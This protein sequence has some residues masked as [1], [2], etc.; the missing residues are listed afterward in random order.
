MIETKLTGEQLK[1]IQADVWSVV[2]RVPMQLRHDTPLHRKEWAWQLM[3]KVMAKGAMGMVWWDT[4]MRPSLMRQVEGSD[5][6]PAHAELRIGMEEALQ[7]E[8]AKLRRMFKPQI[9]E[10]T[11]L[12]QRVCD[13]VLQQADQ[14]LERGTVEGIGLRVSG[15][16]Q[17]GIS[18][19]RRR[20]AA[21][22][23][24]AVDVETAKQESRELAVRK[25]REQ[26]G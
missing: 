11:G 19:G 24:A 8:R 16:F 25:A 12:D 17:A 10:L 4:E 2:Q 20:A 14:W 23:A 3:Q 22:Q 5:G 26:R 7:G 9:R 18:E 1:H 13:A 21:Q 6:A 15:L